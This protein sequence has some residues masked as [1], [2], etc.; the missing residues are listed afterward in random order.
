VKRGFT[1]NKF[2]SLKIEDSENFYDLKNPNFKA[3][4]IAEKVKI[5]I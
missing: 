3:K 4:I 2:S 5:L 1:L